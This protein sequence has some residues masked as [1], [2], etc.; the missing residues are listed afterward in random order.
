MMV[1]YLLR[2][3][4]LAIGFLAVSLTAHAACDNRPG[5]PNNF[6]ATPN[7][8]G[9]SITLTWKNTASENWIYWDIAIFKNNTVMPGLTGV[10]GDLG[11]IRSA[12][13]A[14]SAGSQSEI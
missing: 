11:R 13:G 10:P 9:N 1:N 7:G 12:P 3:F 4:V 8:N 6:K 2:R 14:M 5:T